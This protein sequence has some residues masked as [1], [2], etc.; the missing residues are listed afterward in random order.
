MD[1]PYKRIH[2]IV[3]PAAGKNEPILNVINPVFH[4]QGVQWD[5]SVTLGAGDCTRF[6]RAAAEDGVDVV[7]AYGGDGTINEAVSG[8]VGTGVP[9]MIL[10]GGTNNVLA[11]EF[12]VPSNLAKAVEQLFQSES[13]AVDVGEVEMEAGEVR[14]FLMR[15]EFGLPAAMNEE[16][17]RQLKDSLGPLAYGV[18]A[19][20]ALQRTAR[21]QFTLDLDDGRR[22]EATAVSCQV[23]N[24]SRM[25]SALGA[26]WARH[27]SPYDS[28][29]NVIVGDVSAEGLTSMLERTL[30]L[31]EEWEKSHW[32]CREVTVSAEP[33][34][35]IW[36][37]GEPFG[38]TPKTI[39]VVRGG[40][41]ILIAPQPAARALL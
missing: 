33:V 4:T 22:V 37:D 36:C 28:W 34:Q 11:A 3:N 18:G 29:L 38:Q 13:R 19:V 25:G 30:K 23:L 16:T 8:L 31:G 6:A 24:T 5:V 27:V 40:V 17:T 12:G 41:C 2:V 9:L 1:T 35:S 7:A 20:R 32:T 21:A 10:P 26:T 15:A 39:R 14:Y